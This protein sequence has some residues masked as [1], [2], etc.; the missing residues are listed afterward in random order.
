LGIDVTVGKWRGVNPKGGGGVAE[1]GWAYVRTSR[2]K[3]EFPK[4]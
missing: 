3:K 4:D 2:T 1:T